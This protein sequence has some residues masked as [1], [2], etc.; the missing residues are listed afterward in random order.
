MSSPKEHTRMGALAQMRCPR[1]QNLQDR[2]EDKHEGQMGKRSCWKQRMAG[3]EGKK[4]RRYREQMAFLLVVSNS[5]YWQGN[6]RKT[7][8]PMFQLL[9]PRSSQENSE[10]A[11]NHQGP[12]PPVITVWHHSGVSSQLIWSLI[13]KGIFF[14]FRSW[15]WLIT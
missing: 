12:Q 14:F 10:L 15:W 9:P 6:S 2:G 5:R 13:A 11:K 1:N 4:N 3:I 7:I 8:P